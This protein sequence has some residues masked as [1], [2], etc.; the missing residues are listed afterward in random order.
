MNGNLKS[1]ETLVSELY[2]IIELQK[3]YFLNKKI[4]LVNKKIQHYSQRSYIFMDNQELIRCGS[5]I[6]NSEL[7]GNKIYLILLPKNLH[8]AKIII[9]DFYV[10]GGHC[11]KNETLSRVLQ[12]FWLPHARTVKDTSSKML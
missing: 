4:N 7:N 5:R 9:Y 1:K 8:T 11:E 2:L 3:F 6:K 12:K 10:E